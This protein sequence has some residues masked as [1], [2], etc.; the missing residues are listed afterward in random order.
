MKDKK[1]KIKE[2]ERKKVRGKSSDK[3]KYNK[4]EKSVHCREHLLHTVY[5]LIVIEV[6]LFFFFFALLCRPM[7]GLGYVHFS[8]FPKEDGSVVADMKSS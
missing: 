7:W 6:N 4:N 3:T 2:S 8:F 1:N 5:F